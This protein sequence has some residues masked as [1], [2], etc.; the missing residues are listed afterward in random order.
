[1]R[2]WDGWVWVGNVRWGCG[3]ARAWARA[4]ANWTARCTGAPAPPPHREGAGGRHGDVLDGGGAQEVGGQHVGDDVGLGGGEGHDVGAPDLEHH[5]QLGVLWQRRERGKERQAGVRTGRPAPS[6]PML[7][8]SIHPAHRQLHTLGMRLQ[9]AGGA[10]P[11]VPLLATS[12]TPLAT[13]PVVTTAA[14]SEPGAAATAGV[15]VGG[16]DTVV[17]GP[18]GGEEATATGAGE[19]AATGEGLG[20]GLGDGE[21][22]ETGEGLGDGTGEGEGEG[23]GTGEGDGLGEGEGT[24]DGEGLGEGEGTVTTGTVMGLGVGVGPVSSWNRPARIRQQG[25][26]A[27]AAAPQDTVRRAAAKSHSPANH[28][29]A[30]GCWPP[31]AA[32]SLLL[33]LRAL[34]ATHPARWRG[35]PG[36]PACTA[37]ARSGAAV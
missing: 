34:R 12:V 25:G 10:G 17:G 31:G 3:R 27:Y 28:P 24:G 26:E 15:A 5:H 32:A 9:S 4:G 16:V 33:Q 8:P 14:V 1:M 23:E 30:P 18:A 13:V 7:A 2:A 20:E 19:G 6:P 37:A 29:S 11:P 35:V 36:A 21:G 22:T